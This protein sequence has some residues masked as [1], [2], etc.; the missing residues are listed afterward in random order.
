MWDEKNILSY[1]FRIQEIP[2]DI[3]KCHTANNNGKEAT[4]F[5]KNSKKDV[6]NCFL[7]SLKPELKMR[8]RRSYTNKNSSLTL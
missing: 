7:R 2:A 3:L 8:L 5:N 1:T 4:K 6:I